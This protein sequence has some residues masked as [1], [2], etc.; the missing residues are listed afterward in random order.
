MLGLEEFKCIAAHPGLIGLLP[1][2]LLVGLDLI[3]QCTVFS[4]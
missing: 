1:G 4:S 3:P 2:V